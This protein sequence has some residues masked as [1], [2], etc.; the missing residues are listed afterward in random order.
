MKYKVLFKVLPPR[1]FGLPD[2]DAIVVKTSTDRK[3]LSPTIDIQS[4][5]VISHGTFSEYRSLDEALSIRLISGE[6][7]LEVRDNFFELIVRAENTRSA[8]VSATVFFERFLRHVMADYGDLFEYEIIQVKNEEGEL[9]KEWG[10]RSGKI[11]RLAMY[12]LD[13]LAEQLQRAA[14]RAQVG[15]ESL[16]KALVY[17]E[18]ARFLY[19]ARDHAPPL[20]AHSSM[21][22]T[23][24]YLYLWKALSVLLGEPGTDK[25]FQSRFRV[26]G[27]PKGF[28][29]ERME[30]LYKIRCHYDVA[31]YR[32]EPLDVERIEDAFHKATGVCREVIGAVADHLRK[33]DTPSQ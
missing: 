5:N 28:W 14:D 12:N 8:V 10:D 2:D 6:M 17:Y 11:M 18:H 7:T 4:G 16:N 25:D 9:Q 29:K 23:S 24:A 30:P 32:L 21:I 3:I 27:F 22:L 26:Y 19:K 33:N 20:S 13:N 31:H 1:V 15:D